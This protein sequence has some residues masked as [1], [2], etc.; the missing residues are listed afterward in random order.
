MSP[1]RQKLTDFGDVDEAL[2]DLCA[3]A[4][5]ASR[6]V[7]RCVAVE[8][9]DLPAPFRELLVHHDHMTT[10]LERFHGEPVRLHV[11]REHLDAELYRRTIVL[12]S[13]GTGE[14]VEFGVVRI[15]LGFTPPAVREEVLA[16]QTP[17]GEILIRHDVLRRIEPRWF[18]RFAMDC[19]LIGGFGY[20]VTGDIYGRVG[21]IYCDEEPAIELLEV[22]TGVRREDAGSDGQR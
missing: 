15:D 22:V 10:R 4:V 16:Q 17:L 13:A 2:A 1:V 6:P 7:S 19:P 21:T 11:L 3:G 5:A 8:P 14:V 12:T 20:P 9:D 18:L